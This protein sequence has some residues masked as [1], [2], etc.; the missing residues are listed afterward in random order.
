MYFVTLPTKYILSALVKTSSPRLLSVSEAAFPLA[1]SLA[2]GAGPRASAPAAAALRPAA[3]ACAPAA[4][5][6]RATRAHACAAVT[7]REAAARAP[8]NSL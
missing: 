1:A 5:T 6:P 8:A 2:I 3:S 7:P 4:R